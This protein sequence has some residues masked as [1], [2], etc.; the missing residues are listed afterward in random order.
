MAGVA[1][2]LRPRFVVPVF[3]GSSPIICP[4]FLTGTNMETINIDGKEF[5][6]ID[7]QTAKANILMIK[8]SQGFLACSYFD[9][10]TADRLNEPVALVTGVKSFQDML[11]A[12]V[13]KVSKAAQELGIS[14]EMTGKEALMKI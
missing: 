3:V 7:I 9:I 2:W 5:E 11:E 12:K 1:K 6:A 13:I 4:I 14:E 10:A 8:A